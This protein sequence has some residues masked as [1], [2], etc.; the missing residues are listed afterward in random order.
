MKRSSVKTTGDLMSSNNQ[1]PITAP[2]P[3]PVVFCQVDGPYNAFDRKL[4]LLLLHL[5]FDRL[6]E[7][8]GNGRWHE[9][10]ESE[11]RILIEKYTGSK[12]IEQLWTSAKRLTKTTVEYRR[13]DKKDRRWKG[14]SSLF[15]A[16]IL[17]KNDRD[18]YFRFML[19]PPLVPI[20]LE[21]NRFAR[22]RVE[23]M[24]KL[25]SKYAVTLYQILESIVNLKYAV[26]EA[27]V[28]E[29]RSW[30]KVP[31]GKLSKWKDFNV[32]A[33]SPAL[34]EINSNPELSGVYVTNELIRNGKGGKVQKIK[35]IVRKTDRR[36]QF[37]QEIQTA[38]RSKRA[39]EI[40]RLIPPFN[41]T[42]VYNKAKKIA[43]GLDVHALED[44][45]REWAFSSDVE[46]K[47]PKAHFLA[48][49]K[50]KVDWTGPKG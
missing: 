8:S 29:V 11:L 16:E 2:V 21:P 13:V 41:G 39:S 15:M 36:I 24:L 9:I 38:K 42:E 37:E 30:L 49:V 28:D 6:A 26:L 7:K 14:I 40:S 48:F 25:D 20:I 27:T 1:L 5:E 3:L 44:E 47:N 34:N 45:W 10:K 22:L 12:D 50:K 4:W 19:P 17:E 23:F 31:E 33:L 32:K 18:G 46:V 35:F 43:P